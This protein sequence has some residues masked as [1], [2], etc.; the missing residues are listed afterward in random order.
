MFDGNK[1]RTFTEAEVK[2]LIAQSIQQ[3]Q[4]NALET[5]KAVGAAVAEGI[6]HPAPTAAE[7]ESRKKAMDERI[8]LAK[9]DEAAKARR[10]A[11]CNGQSNL[12]HR[13]PSDP[14]FQGNFAG[15]SLIIWQLTQ[16]SS[17]GPN[18]EKLM[19]APTP[20]GCCQWC[21]TTFMPN[22]PDYAEAISWGVNTKM[23]TAPM[24]IRTGN[25]A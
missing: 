20:V 2:E 6:A 25:W 16:F 11:Q 13:R 15:Q 24:N 21:G 19:S 1:E 9:I 7:L 4:A 5:A 17:F 12:P 14:V 10:R 22:D 3:S 23:S 18:G 8:Q